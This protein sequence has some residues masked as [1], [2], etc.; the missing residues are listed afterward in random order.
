MYPLFVIEF[1]A[2][3]AVYMWVVLHFSVNIVEPLNYPVDAMQE[4]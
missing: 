1:I 4:G 3:W 2:Y